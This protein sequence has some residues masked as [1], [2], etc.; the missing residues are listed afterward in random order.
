M[1]RSFTLFTNAEPY[2]INQMQ[3]ANTIPH[4]FGY[5]LQPQ[6]HASSFSPEFLEVIDK[7]F[8]RWVRRCSAPT[9]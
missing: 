6:L 1:L 4:E 5:G 3:S 9:V 7:G 2:L 8:Y